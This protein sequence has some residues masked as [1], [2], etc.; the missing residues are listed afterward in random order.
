MTSTDRSI[1]SANL[2]LADFQARFVDQFAAEAGPG[3][4]HVLV[5]PIGSGKKTATATA[6]GRLLNLGS[7]DRVLLLTRAPLCPPWQEQLDENAIEAVRIDGRTFRLL[8]NTLMHVGSW[9]AGVFV[10]SID[11]AKR[12]D[13][14]SLLI[15]IPWDLVVL[16]DTLGLKGLRL[17]LLEGFMGA[18]PQPALLLIGAVA[19]DGTP[20]PEIR[21][22][23]ESA[24]VVNWSNDFADYRSRLREERGSLVRREILAYSRSAEEIALVRCIQERASDLGQMR[25]LALLRRAM[26][27]ISCVETM[28]YGLL[29]HEASSDADAE[30]SE[31][32]LSDVVMDLPDVAVSDVET[33]LAEELLE[34]VEN[35]HVDARL[36]ALRQLLERINDEGM[37]H[38]VVFCDYRGT[39]DYLVAAIHGGSMLDMALHG[40]IAGEQR[41]EILKRFR[42]EGGALCITT[43]ASEGVSLNFVD[44]AIHFDL[45]V[46]PLLFA[47][48]EGRYDRF[49]RE[50]PCAV[51]FFRDETGALP[52]EEVL[53]DMVQRFEALSGPEADAGALFDELLP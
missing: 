27:S 15:A 7:C 42:K 46:S 3:S 28:L 45:P 17:R 49:G 33:R 37:R 23:L 8:R 51:F 4:R 47:Q 30:L 52:P 16:E 18:T 50:T 20:S 21:A 19:H 26:S 32:T 11:L 41:Q 53:L 2:V 6:V 13:V 1:D 43:A 5:G 14:A 38:T 34:L 35:I 40:G 39:L 9:P 48:R 12:E 29:A 36:E 22:F 25:G 10:M 31:S 24:N 44:A